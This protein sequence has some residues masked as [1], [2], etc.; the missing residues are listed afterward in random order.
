MLVEPCFL[1]PPKA[2]TYLLPILD[3]DVFGSRFIFT[4][5]DGLILFFQY[6]IEL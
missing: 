5:L 6:N 3:G 1:L 2:N 4:Q